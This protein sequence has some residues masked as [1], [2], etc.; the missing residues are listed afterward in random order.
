[1]ASFAASRSAY[2]ARVSRIHPSGTLDQASSVRCRS[3]RPQQ[4]TWRYDRAMRTPVC[5]LLGIEQPL[6][7]APIGPA[8]VPR[9]VASVSNAGALGML[10]LTW[11]ADSAA[12][13]RETAAMT[14][15]PF[16]GNFVIAWDQHERIENALEA[17][18]RIVSLSFGD[19]TEYVEQV[20]ASGGLVLHSVGSAEEA[21]RA[22]A[23][24]VDVVVAQG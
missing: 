9:L 19:P 24:G 23:A 3:K 15:S 21:K 13:V 2:P 20:H 6:V 11:F 7:Q 10:A 14:S 22:V 4:R 18:L 16:G 12:V 17:G 8:A 5:E 1:M